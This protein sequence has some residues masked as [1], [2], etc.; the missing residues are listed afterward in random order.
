M[1]VATRYKPTWRKFTSNKTVQRIGWFVLQ[2]SSGCVPPSQSRGTTPA[3][4][5]FDQNMLLVPLSPHRYA[6]HFA[7]FFC[8]T[9]PRPWDCT[10]D[11]ADYTW[12]HLH[13]TSNTIFLKVHQYILWACYSH[14]EWE[15][16]WIPYRK[17]H[18]EILK[19]QPEID[20]PM[21]RCT[22]N[23]S[24]KGN[25][26]WGWTF[27]WRASKKSSERVWPTLTTTIS[28]SWFAICILKRH[29]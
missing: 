8:L 9:L 3:I 25:V 22:P 29:M 27:S 2:R 10:S 13:V 4:Y 11:Y 28:L 5:G 19:G 6:Q 24:V 15:A 14:K 18:L 21:P 17:L 12:C 16:C 7:L 20:H 1:K 26:C 23:H